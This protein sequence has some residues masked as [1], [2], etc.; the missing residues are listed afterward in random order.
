MHIDR[1]HDNSGYIEQGKYVHICMYLHGRS[2][3]WGL[4]WVELK[5][6]ESSFLPS[7][8]PSFFNG[9]VMVF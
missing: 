6:L 7:F 1:V 2:P 5:P 4:I 8:L 3:V 9:H